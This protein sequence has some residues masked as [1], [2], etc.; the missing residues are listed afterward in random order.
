M[1]HSPFP[2]SLIHCA[3]G[4]A[5]QLADTA[6]QSLGFRRIT[7]AGIL[8]PADRGR[9]GI[10]QRFHVKAQIRHPEHGQTGLPGAEEIAGATE[11]QILFRDLEAVGGG[12]KGFQP[13]FGLR[14]FGL[15]CQ[16]TEALYVIASANTR[17]F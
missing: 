10:F 3:L 11:L 15:R 16:N 9:L 5:E 1:A 13:C 14:V 17:V 7:S 6:A 4:A 2:T 12:A 8:D